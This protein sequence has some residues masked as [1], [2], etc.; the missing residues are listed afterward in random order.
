MVAV[1]ATAFVKPAGGKQLFLRG[2]LALF[3][4]WFVLCAWSALQ[5]DH[6]MATR[7]ATLFGLPHWLLLVVCAALLGGLVSGLTALAAGYVRNLL[8]VTAAPK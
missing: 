3:I 5:N 7:I 2:F 6:I 1:F 8:P 4:S